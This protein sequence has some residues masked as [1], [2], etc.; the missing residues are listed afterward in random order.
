MG[1]V[2]RAMLGRRLD[3]LQAQPAFTAHLASVLRSMA[4]DG[5]GVAWLPQSLVEEDF[6]AKR[7]VPA[8]GGEWEVEL[9]IRLYRQ[10]EAVG[11]AAEAVWKA[12]VG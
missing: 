9:E 5:R 6:G 1:R 4:M 7:L 2:V 8:A 3:A 10:R 11:R 12:A